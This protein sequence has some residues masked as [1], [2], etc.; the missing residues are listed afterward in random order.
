MSEDRRASPR[1]T[2]HVA[3]EIETSA[4]KSSIAITRD[5]S[6]NGLLVFSRRELAIGE[7][8]KIRLMKGRD[9]LEVA[10]KVVRQEEL[11]P[12]ES[13]LWRTKVGVLVEDAAQLASMIEGKD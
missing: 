4:G 3:A 2:A 10:A 9:M 13:T 7:T 6:A 1:R 5:V 12:D 11:T 8:I